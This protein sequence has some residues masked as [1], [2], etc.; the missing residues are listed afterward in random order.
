MDVGATVIVAVVVELNV[1]TGGGAGSHPLNA[2][3]YVLGG[4]LAVPVLFRHK[5]PLQVLIACSALLFIYYV[6]GFRRNISP[7]PVLSLP[8]Y[9]AALAGYLAVTIVIPVFY[10]AVGLLVVDATTHEGLV[11]LASDFL[12]Q[13]VVLALAIMLGEVV[14]SRRALAAETADRLRLAAEERESE[15]ARR[16]AE[17]R[18]RIARELHDTVAHSMATITVQAG[19][20]LHVLGE[21][22]AS[23][24]G[25]A[26]TGLAGAG[27]AEAGPRVT[28]AL[29]AIRDTSKGALTD[30]RL[31]LDQLRGDGGV[32]AAELRA[33]GLER[34]SALSDAVRAAGAAVSVTIEGEQVPLPPGID[35]AAYRIL[36][37][38]LTN[39]LRHAGP[40]A[41]AAVCLR[42]APDALTI[43]VTDDGIGPSGG[44]ANGLARGGPAA[45]SGATNSG[46]TA[47]GATAGGDGSARH[48]GHVGGHGL[49]GMSERAAAVGGRLSAGPRDSGGFEVVA[50]LPVASATAVRP[51]ASATRA[52]SATPAGPAG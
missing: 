26:S 9:D 20:A 5:W 4:I 22:A 46:A 7:A 43:R 38:S 23:G 16:V 13:A 25:S 34:L 37:E 35:H 31:T 27:L 45:N 48:P 39:V 51:D 8:L 1:A 24:G 21:S 14:R 47:G 10:L 36:Q 3:A 44:N 32:D 30:M 29:I 18:L 19:S 40:D 41:R 42:Y 52:N 15:T 12:P 28:D 17:E 11:T 33:A 50:T 6:S 49:D 2:L